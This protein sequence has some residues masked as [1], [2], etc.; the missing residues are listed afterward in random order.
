MAKDKKQ[1]IKVISIKP[2]RNRITARFTTLQNVQRAS[3]RH[4]D[5][6][7]QSYE[8]SRDQVRH[9]KGNWRGR[10]MGKST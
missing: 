2:A 1:D 8:G 10:R 6:G 5:E 9:Q 4:L 7:L 3:R